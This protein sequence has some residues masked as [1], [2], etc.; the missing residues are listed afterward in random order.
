MKENRDYKGV[1]IPK[2]ISYSKF[3]LSHGLNRNN[4]WGI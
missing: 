2:E 1:W 4:G 3:C